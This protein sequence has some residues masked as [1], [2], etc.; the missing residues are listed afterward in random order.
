M[1][2]I[3]KSLLHCIVY[4]IV[5]RKNVYIYS[6]PSIPHTQNIFALQLVKSTDVEPRDRK[7]WLYV[8]GGGGGSI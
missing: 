6:I 3:N 5:A 8:T 4:G 7:G 2:C 1:L